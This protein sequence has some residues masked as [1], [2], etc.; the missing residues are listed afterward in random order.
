MPGRANIMS[1][2][3]GGFR[4][5]VTIRNVPVLN[6]HGGNVFWVD[7]GDGSNGYKGTFDRPF[8]TIDKAIG[9]C[10]ANNGDIIMVKAGHTENVTTDGGIA[11]DVAGISIIGLGAGTDRP[12]ITVD[13]AAAAVVTVTA[14]NITFHNLLFLGDKN[15]LVAC[16]EIAGDSCEVSHCEFRESTNGMI[17]AITVGVADGDADYTYIHDCKF[18]MDEPG[19]T[20]VGD[21]AIEIIKDSDHITIENNHIY[22][23]FDDAAVHVDTGGNACDFLVIR[24]NYIENTAT[25][26][27]AIEVDTGGTM[28]GGSITDNRLVGDTSAA[29]LEPHTLQCLGN[30]GNLGETGSGDFPIPG[31]QVGSRGAR[32]V[33]ATSSDLSTGYG[34]CDDP[35]LFTVTGAVAMRI[36]G[37]VTTAITSTCST[38]TLSVGVSDNNTLFTPAITMDGTNGAQYDILANASTTVNGDVLETNGQYAFVANGVNVQAFIATNDMTNGAVDWY[39]EWFPV[40]SDGDVKS[41]I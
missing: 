32:V 2:Y 7:S 1:N 37:V 12:T 31:Y 16:L 30:L 4:Q 8:A 22:G 26:N 27:Y 13:T 3:P 10:T 35:A 33:K 21:A 28:N 5:G 23:D 9:E 24:G 11:A 19:V 17:T 6:A 34:T 36:W 39:C 14:A 40:S 38:G 15:D 20:N 41:A 29:L 25:G 18:Y